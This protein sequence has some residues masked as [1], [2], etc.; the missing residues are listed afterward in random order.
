MG[1]P[2][3]RG[4]RGVLWGAGAGPGVCPHARGRLPPLTGSA[5]LSV[6]RTLARGEAPS[7]QGAFYFPRRDIYRSS[8]FLGFFC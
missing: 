7:E 3:R 8:G 6:F 2:G 5:L 4:R 1:R